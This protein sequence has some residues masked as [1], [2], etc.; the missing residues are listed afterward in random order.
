MKLAIGA[1]RS[2]TRFFA[3][4]WR[5]FS[6]ADKKDSE[7]SVQINREIKQAMEQ[8]LDQTIRQIKQESQKAEVLPSVS[9]MLEQLDAPAVIEMRAEHSTLMIDNPLTTEHYLKTNDEGAIQTENDLVI[10]LSEN[11]TLAKVLTERRFDLADPSIAVR[12]STESGLF[13]DP[14][15]D[16]KTISLGNAPVMPKDTVFLGDIDPASIPKNLDIALFREDKEFVVVGKAVEVAEGELMEDGKAAGT[17]K[18]E[19]V[20]Q[21]VF[22][23][24]TLWDAQKSEFAL[25]ERLLRLEP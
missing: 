2:R 13:F 12:N 8:H 17:R 25:L 10:R 19:I 9:G 20:D 23:E 11:P 24:A 1:M 4:R 3:N 21:D 18:L 16:F 6:E 7:L 5:N 14:E 22:V 15:A